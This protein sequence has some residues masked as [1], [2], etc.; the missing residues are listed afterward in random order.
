MFSGLIA[1]GVQKNLNGNLGMPSWEWYFIIEGSVTIVWGLLVA[2]FLPKLP[3]TVAKRG[4]WL[5][6][7]EQEHS[8]IM[9]RTVKGESFRRRPA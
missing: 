9:H 6:R 3:E 1:Y 5:F 7:S 4:S 2:G 8:M